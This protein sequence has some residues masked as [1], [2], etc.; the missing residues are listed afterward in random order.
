MPGIFGFVSERQVADAPG[1][2]RA[3][4]AL[5]A[6]HI[7]QRSSAICGP[8]WGL[9]ASWIPG[10]QSDPEPSYV[11]DLRS[12]CAAVGEVYPSGESTTIA[13]VSP[14]LAIQQAIA[15]DDPA[16]LARVNGQF[17]GAAI[18][19]H[20]GA[21]D[22]VCDRYGLH[23]LYWT[24]RN[25]VFAFASEAKALL[26]LPG[27]GRE[28]DPEGVAAFLLLGEQ[29]SDTTLL[30]G[31]K[32]APAAS[33]I[34]SSGGAPT[35]QSW[36]RIRYSRA[37]KRSQEAEAVREAGR[38][39]RRAVERQTAGDERIGIPLSG[40]LDSRICLAAVPK[41][42]RGAVTTF[43]WGDAGC[44]DRTFARAVARRCEARHMEF[45]YRYE[46]L[47]GGAAR[48]AWITDGMAGATDFHILSY[49]HDLAASSGVI[50]NGF[51]GDVVLGGNFHWRSV[52]SLPPSRIAQGAFAKRND[53]LPL[54]EAGNCLRGSAIGAARD[55]PASFAAALR[56]HEQQD[57]LG[58]LDAFL[59]DSRVRR[60]T[61]FGTQLLRSR[62]VSRAPFYDN[63]FF[64]HIATVPPEWRTEHHFYRQVLLHSF[65]EVARI[66]W[67]T[68]GFPA[69]WPP[70]VFRPVGVAARRALGL[71]E[72]ATRGMVPSPY[73]VARIARAFRGSI[74]TR[75][76]SD[77]F[78]GSSFHWEVF[79]RNAGERIWRELQSG[80]DGRA[81]LVGVLLS[82]RFF[83]DQC[84]A[85]ERDMPLP[86]DRVVVTTVAPG[87]T[88][89]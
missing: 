41:E 56:A 69:S 35:V 7:D 42:R 15:L 3:M 75:L 84:R 59:L 77:L 28:L 1:I 9:G 20:T 22:L 32:V 4:G 78:D 14:R 18:D 29:F 80:A 54:G 24:Q 81:K 64:D 43:T 62:L 87:A 11:A 85:S 50:L 52:R 65:P 17:A 30:A 5:L 72:R 76:R 82:L 25:G 58:T 21:V 23:P 45:D 40:G 37:L 60:W 83:V 73:P 89:A 67:Q 55:L 26:A 63:D 36:W 38:L 10:L 16:G 57:P 34:R 2:L 51:A 6:S 39:F 68:T 48:G 49:V 46:A 13:P 19:S 33:R 70:Q 61:S 53:C 12:W 86:P 66:G 44:L 79:D 27:V 47:V 31:V 88:C 74:A 8:Q 71:L